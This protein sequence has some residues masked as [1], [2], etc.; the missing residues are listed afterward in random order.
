M[1]LTFSLI[2]VLRLAVILIV[3]PILSQA[4]QILDKPVA[5][6]VKGQPVSE[7]L[8]TISEQGKF[9]FSYNSNIVAG[10][11]LV[12]LNV[13]QKPVRDVLNILFQD[14]YQYREKG[15]YVIILPAV[16]DR[17]IYISGY[18]IDQEGNAPVDYASVYSRQLLVSTMSGDDGHFR[19]RVRERGFPVNLV[20]SKVGY[21]DTTV[22]IG[23]PQ[24]EDMRIL[25]NQKAVDLDPL[26]VRYS[27]G[28]STWLG[29]LFLSART[30]MQS[31]NISRFFTALPYQASLTPGLGTHGKLSP[32][33]VN[34]F[35]L[36][37]LGGYTAG[38]NGA[39]LA[40]GFN[41]SRQDVRYLQIAGAFNV[42]S[43]KVEGV[44]IAGFHNQIIDSLSGV[45][46]SGFSGIVKK[47]VRG[48]QVSG[49]MNRA[50]D[51]FEGVQVSGALGIIGGNG[52]GVQVSGAVNHTSG[53]FR[54]VQIGG[55][56]NRTRQSLQGMQITG[57]LNI[58]K[59]EMRGVQLGTFNSAKILRGF[60]LGV[61]NV[62]DSSSGVSFGLIN[63]I[64]KSTSNISVYAT[65]IT[66]LNVAWKMGTHRF[67]SILTAGADAGTE[68]RTYQFGFGV[69]KEFFPFKKV[70]FLTEFVN[71]NIYQGSWENTPFLY[72]F[73]TAVTWKPVK[74]FVIFAG[75][76][77]SFY[78]NDQK[79]P[80]PEYKTYPPG[81]YP[82]TKISDKV[83]SWLG[84]H[85]GVSWRYGRL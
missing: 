9:Y 77:Y 4:Q 40:G 42:V 59:N 15:D 70:G 37:I 26:I 23:Q 11:S 57:G 74:R 76:A 8:K 58:V 67:Y 54:G 36:N 56:A 61:L 14:K 31:R 72:R 66:P 35:S 45:Q 7:V 52:S 39:E 83:S 49:F 71:L 69:G 2:R 64:R 20:I 19:L 32:Q 43:G 3:I 30:R 34:K 16:K 73:Q 68:K 13:I 80:N 27:E 44:Q 78:H 22:V 10:D 75:P 46:L 41:I 47:R 25:I 1:N 5:I 60:Q 82:S 62:A 29:R 85:G 50:R 51:T 55:A 79:E 6:S 65:E 63:I 33:V 48:V 18:V 21:A 24:R 53:D 81:N 17:T 84:W 38:V 28:Q 12:T